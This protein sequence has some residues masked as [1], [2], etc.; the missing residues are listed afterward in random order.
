MKTLWFVLSPIAY[1]EQR[2]RILWHNEAHLLNIVIRFLF[3]EFESSMLTK[4]LSTSERSFFSFCLLNAFTVRYTFQSGDLKW[5]W[6]LEIIMNAWFFVK[7]IRDRTATLDRLEAVGFM[8]LVSCP[9][10]LSSLGFELLR[11][12][13][14]T[15][16]PL[17]S[18][19]RVQ[20]LTTEKLVSRSVNWL[21]KD[22][23]SS[24][25]FHSG[26]DLDLFL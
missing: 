24:F 12:H 15:C 10:T 11:P 18:L 13:I 6:R 16:T 1:W 21:D 25:I 9:D 22:I 20:T 2:E 5:S 3:A 17:Y 26:C 4:L 23:C 8:T 14:V 7:F 19:Q